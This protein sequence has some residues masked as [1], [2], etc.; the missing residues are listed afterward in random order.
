MFFT[1]PR[2]SAMVNTRSTVRK[3]KQLKSEGQHQTGMVL[4][5]EEKSIIMD[6]E[7]PGTSRHIN[8][9]VGK[10][11]SIK[12]EM[13]IPA[14]QKSTSIK[15]KCSSSSIL[16]QKR[17]LELEAAKEK[18]RIEIELIEKKLAA[19]LAAVEEK[20]SPI[21][22]ECNSQEG[23]QKIEEWLQ[24]SQQEMEKQ[25]A[26]NNGTMKG[27]M[28]PPPDVDGTNARV[29]AAIVSPLKPLK[30]IPMSQ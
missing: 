2:S 5:D 15:S 10:S 8:V 26:N 6:S 4:D 27:S 21:A 28:F 14:S 7:R 12:N 20:Y 22:S 30:C 16:A 9:E 25:K 3:E 11:N 13:N 18:A 29:V 19:D 23:D 1:P 17:R 24:R